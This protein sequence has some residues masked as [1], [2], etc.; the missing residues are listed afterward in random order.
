MTTI[1]L[2]MAQAL[3]RYVAAQRVMIDGR[4]RRLVEGVW[5]IFGHGNVSVLNGGLPKWEAE[6]RPVESTV[7]P[8]EA[9]NF[10][11]TF[12]ADL[13]RNADDMLDN[14]NSRKWQVA[15]ARAAGR[16]TGDEPEP[17]AG[18]RSGH[19]PGSRSLPFQK[20]LNKDRT[21]APA[22]EI[23]AAFTA[24]G[25]DLEAPLV[26]TCGSGV[27]A[28][29]LALGGYLVGTENIAIYDG[30][31]SDWGAREDTPVATGVE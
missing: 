19:I 11:A 23:K 10:T 4:E 30:S 1:R 6:Q 31:W 15:D 13:V 22:A 24:G 18:M 21:L 7:Q 25:V 2:T 17:R 12:R 9:C 20:L 16:F 27:T 14:I 3:V 8:R 29:V 28:C 5:A 26:T